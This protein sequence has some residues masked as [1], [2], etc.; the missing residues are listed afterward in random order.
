MVRPLSPKFTNPILKAAVDF[1]DDNIKTKKVLVHCN[2]GRSRSPSI[3]MVYLAKNQIISN[4]YNSAIEEFTKKYPEYSP[5]NG[6]E[7]YL[8]KNWEDLMQL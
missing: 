8:K 6:I 1:I 2:L 4:E 5:G 7:I 3:A